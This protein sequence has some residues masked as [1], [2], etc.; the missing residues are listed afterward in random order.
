[1]LLKLSFLLVCSVA[2]V[3]SNCCIRY[4][5]RANQIGGM[6]TYCQIPFPC[7][8]GVSPPMLPQGRFPNFPGGGNGV[9]WGV[10]NIPFPGLPGTGYYRNARDADVSN[11]VRNF[12]LFYY[13]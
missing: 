5:Q 7:L 13:F 6:D 3:A 12:V 4:G 10:S 2:Y 9:N 1:M 8:G 11:K